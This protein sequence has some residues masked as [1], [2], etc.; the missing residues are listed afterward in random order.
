MKFSLILLLLG[1]FSVYGANDRDFDGVDDSADRCLDTPF[2]DLVDANGCTTQTLYTQT[3][4]DIIVGVNFSTMN[5]ATLKNTATSTTTFQAD[6]YHGN[7]SAQLLTSYFRS[8]EST[9]S[10][11]GW[12]DTQLSLFYT[13]KA[14]ESVIVQT[15]VGA[16]LPTYSTGYGNEAIDYRGSIAMQYTLQPQ[17]NLFGGYSYTLVNDAD[18]PKVALF[19]NTH[20]FYGGLGYTTPE[21]NS[22]NLSYAH[23]QSIYTQV[24]PIQ[25]LSLGLFIAITPQWFILGDY[26]YGLSDSASD[27]ETAFRLGYSF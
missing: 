23:S 14:A 7:L 17:I 26:K 6:L 4:Y 22:I 16:V 18:I 9:Y 24:N 15:G 27:H 12:N 19:Q 1:M 10:D 20:A 3:D 5:T 8:E 25:T 21:N 13:V 2:S 11:T